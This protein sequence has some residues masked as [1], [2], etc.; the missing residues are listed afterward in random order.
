GIV[1]V[2]SRAAR[3]A[4]EP[5]TTRTFTGSEASSIAACRIRSKSPS[6]DR[7]STAIFLPSAYMGG[8]CSPV[9]LGSRPSAIVA[10]RVGT[11]RRTVPKQADRLAMG[12]NM[13]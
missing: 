12:C 5:Y 10:D 2:A 8:P 7:Y 11:V 9:A 4:G 3:V 13:G 1:E 6:A